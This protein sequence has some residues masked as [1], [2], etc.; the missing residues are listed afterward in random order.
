ME[1]DAYKNELA[2]KA[3]GLPHMREKCAKANAIASQADANCQMHS[4]VA[5]QAEERVKALGFQLHQASMRAEH[6]RTKCESLDKDKVALRNEVQR[7]QELVSKCHASFDY[8]SKH[9]KKVRRRKASH[10]DEDSRESGTSYPSTYYKGKRTDSNPKQFY[11]SGDGNYKSSGS[12]PKAQGQFG[13]TEQN[14][15]GERRYVN[16]KNHRKISFGVTMAVSSS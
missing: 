16:F 4:R 5:M 2:S 3:D 11:Q 13:N 7:M 1:R 15:S 14:P 9:V 10:A 8:E 6:E 12:N